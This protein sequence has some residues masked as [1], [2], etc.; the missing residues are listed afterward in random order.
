MI[1]LAGIAKWPAV[2]VSTPEG[3]LR[4]AAVGADSCSH[5]R[6]GRGDWGRGGGSYWGVDRGCR[7]GPRGKVR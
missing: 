5:Q 2:V 6:G 4:G 3:G 1:K 7:G